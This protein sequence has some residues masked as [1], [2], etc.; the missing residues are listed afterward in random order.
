MLINFQKILLESGS[1]GHESE[2]S[3]Q[4]LWK[5]Q[6]Q[7]RVTKTPMKPWTKSSIEKEN[8]ANVPLSDLLNSDDSVKVVLESL[9]TYGVAFINKVP[10]T[11][12][13]T[14]MALKR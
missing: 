12:D 7:N 4:W 14:E 10:P 8:Y 6:V 5:S 1:D 3:F 13:M 2:Y 9:I 11:T